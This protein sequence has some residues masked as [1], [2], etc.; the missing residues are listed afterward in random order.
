M[1]I[2]LRA[3]VTLLVTSVLLTE[4]H[5]SWSQLPVIAFEVLTSKDGLPSN[6]VLSATRDHSGFMWFGTRLCPVRYD[7]TGFK[8]FTTYT[9]NF[10]TGIK[11]IRITIFGFH[12]TEVE[13]LRLMPGHGNGSASQDD[14]EGKS[15]TTGDFYIDHLG[16][17][18]YSDHFGVNRIDLETK[19]HKHYPFRQTTFVWLKAAFMED[20]DSNVWVIGRDNGLFR[21]DRQADTLRCILGMDSPSP[22]KL[23][24]LLLTNA[25]V[26]VMDFY[27]SGRTIMD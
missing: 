26:G 15:K 17:G 2:L 3:V 10:I 21:Y 18:W 5:K 4:N 23:D 22:K 19:K 6:T 7:G 16:E 20:L 14:K 24:Q 12:Q 25:T 8:S 1:V 27:G 9:T 13:F 11:P